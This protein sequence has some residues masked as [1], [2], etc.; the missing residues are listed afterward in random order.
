MRRFLTAVALVALSAGPAGADAVIERYSRSDGFAGLGGFES[1]TVETTSAAAQRDETRFKFT[2]GFLGALQ[3]MAGFG[4]NVR[5]TRLDR[6]LV[7]VLDPEKRTYTEQPLTAK[8]ERQRTMPGQRP[9]RERAEPSDVVV[10]RNELKVEKTGAQKTINAFP[11]EEYLVTWVVET[12]NQ[13]TGETGKSLMTNRLWTTSETAEIRAVQAEEQ[14]YSQ[15]YLKKLGL[16]MSPVEAQRFLA[17]LAGLTEEEQQRAL[18]KLGAEMGKVQ[19]YPIVSQ[20]EWTAEGIAG[21]PPAR[22]GAPPAGGAG[23]QPA[24]G[25]LFGKLLGGG[26]RKSGGGAQ[27]TAPPAG[28]ERRGPLFGFY[29]EVK[30]LRTVPAEPARFEVPA[31][32]T[33]R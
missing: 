32:F 29:T 28:P 7:W 13:K 4:D 15:A 31:G 9:P 24:L 25:E 18:A 20:L 17:G 16:E 1:T 19:G 5:I 14:A 33:R 2:S 22:E 3:K 26:A 21:A 8:G 11:C 6:D 27:T 10:T 23:G 30:S 12:R